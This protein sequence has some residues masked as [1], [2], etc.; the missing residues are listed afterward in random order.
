VPTNSGAGGAD[1][2]T[3]NTTNSAGGGTAWTSVVRGTGATLVYDVDGATTWYRFATAGTSTSANVSWTSVTFPVSM[4]RVYGGFWYRQV[5]TPGT[6]QIALIRVRASSTQAMRITVVSGKLQIRNTS[7]TV[8]ATST[9]TLTP[10]TAYFVRWDLTTGT[11][12]TGVAVVELFTEA[13]VFVETMTISGQNFG[14]AAVNETS[15]GIVANTANHPAYQLRGFD[16]NTTGW[17]APPTALVGTLTENFDAGTIDT[18]KW[19][20][21]YGL[22]SETG[23]R[24]RTEYQIASWSALQSA[25]GYTLKGSSFHVQ[26]FMTSAPVGATFA[27]GSII[28]S[29]MTPGADLTIQIDPVGAEI[30][31]LNR[32]GYDDPS[33]VYL[34]YDPV[35]HSFIRLRE[36]AGTLYFETSPDAT[37]WTTQRSVTT[38]AWINTDAQMAILEAY[39]DAGTAGGYVEWDYLNLLP[40]EGTSLPAGR[41]VS[42]EVA[43][44]GRSRAAL[45]ADDFTGE[46]VDG[47][48]WF[49]SYGTVSQ[50]GG[51]ARVPTAVGAWSAFQSGRRYSLTGSQVAV[52]VYPPA[53]GGAVT[54][55]AY[56]ALVVTSETE[57]TSLFIMVDVVAGVLVMR[58]RAGYTDPAEVSIT[59]DPVAHAWFRLREDAGT[60]Y[61]ETS[62]DA[63]T[64]TTRRSVTTPGWLATDA[65]TIALESHRDAGTN[66]FA[67]FDDLNPPPVDLVVLPAGQA[68]EVN[69]ARVGA[70]LVTAVAGRPAEVDTAVAGQG[71]RTLSGGRGLDAQAAL[72]G[73]GVKRAAAGRAASAELGRAIVAGAKTGLAGRAA[74]AELARA[75][76]G[77]RTL[78]AAT[79]PAETDTAL[80]GTG[81]RTVAGGRPLEVDTAQAGTGAKTGTA[82]RALEVDAGRVGAGVKRAAA[83]RAVE[84]NVARAGNGG[85]A[86][87]AGRAV[88]TDTA[89]AGTGRAVMPAGRAVETD[90]ARAIV[91]GAKVGLAGRATSPETGRAGTGAKRA[92]GGR[93]LEVDLGRPAAGRVLVVGGR[94]LEV[95]LGRAGGGAAV[96]LAGRATE[97]DT[98]RAG[99]GRKTLAAGRAVE[100]STGRP[101]VG[102]R[103]GAGG[104]ALEA[105]LGRPGAGVKTGLAGRATSAEIGRPGTV[106][107]FVKLAAGRAVETSVGRPGTGTKRGTGVQVVEADQARAGAARVVLAAGRAVETDTARA[108]TGRKTGTAARAVEV[109]LARAGGGLRRMPAGRAVET[110]VARAAAG[111]RLGAGGRAVEADVAR[112]GTSST[113]Q[114]GV[115]GRGVETDLGRPAAGRKTGTAG[116]ALEVDVARAGTTT[117]GSTAGRA[118]ETDLGRAAAGRKTGTAG[119]RGT[120]VQAAVAGAGVKRAA[121]GRAVEANVGRPGTVAVRILLPAGRAVSAELA[122]AGAGV[123][124]CVAGRAVEV[125]TAIGLAPRLDPVAGGGARAYSTSGAVRIYGGT[126]GAHVINTSGRVRIL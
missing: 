53:V 39:Q 66:D 17:P 119:G 78:A 116:R 41:A 29:S 64:W 86:L 6:T 18:G 73:A 50:T 14:G 22:V 91:A 102:R 117:T 57:G 84:Q 47:D 31:F 98:A 68:V 25:R 76:S 111:R 20:N 32:T 26:V 8:V 44:R 77:R 45:L 19:P 7:N 69:E 10:A 125:D 72:P 100:S 4:S 60:T 16:V 11:T 87:V 97:T 80:A 115:A 67:E 96:K 36:A 89:R 59:Y 42:P 27:Y 13:G 109:D 71:R 48:K 37:T 55:E 56:A 95:D 105:D 43:R 79:R 65:S 2:V 54:G 70:G 58:N 35:A 94:A 114:T 88:E 74:S 5:G 61:F 15:F 38:P 107:G 93:A 33:G 34:T 82:G 126:G 123:K 40:P 52:R 63:T 85:Q 24:G 108:G 51:R 1:E 62:P 28:V 21:S 104:R 121:A 12:T 92:A 81:R 99:T 9:A 3:V 101:G 106:P 120:D 46:V 30:A 110:D 122:G 118:V 23:G 49:N 113:G 90:V 124:R 75:G 103:L 112:P 83:G